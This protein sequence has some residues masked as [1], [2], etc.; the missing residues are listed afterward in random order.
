[1]PRTPLCLLLAAATVLVPIHVP[2]TAVAQPRPSAIPSA[3][4]DGLDTHLFRPALDSRGLVSVN[5]VGVLGGCDVRDDQRLVLGRRALDDWR[6]TTG[7]GVDFFPGGVERIVVL[8]RLSAA[9]PAFLLACGGGAAATSSAP[10][11]AAAVGVS[12]APEP[13]SKS[14][15]D[16]FSCEGAHDCEVKGTLA[17]RS[18]NAA[19]AG[20]RMLEKA[21]KLGSELGCVNLAKAFFNGW[22]GGVERPR[23]LAL[24]GS[25]CEGG[26][27]RACRLHAEILEGDDAARARQLFER[28]CTL[29]DVSACAQ[30]ALMLAKGEGGPADER[31]AGEVADQAC[32]ADDAVGCI[33]FGLLARDGMGMPASAEAARTAFHRG[34]TLGNKD[35]CKA[36]ADLR[37][38]ASK[39]N[40]LPA[41]D[42]PGANITVESIKADGTELKNIACKTDGLAGMLG[43]I[44]LGAG[45]KSRKGQLDACSPKGIVDTRVAWKTA[46]SR[47]SEV[48][49]TGKDAATSRCVERALAGAPSTVPGVCA[50]TVVHGKR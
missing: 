12:P 43:G 40:A 37:R 23:A 34:C 48:H 32:K 11:K 20:R 13:A 14:E 25:S 30:L 26:S 19:P 31:R 8:R 18:S 46:G 47:M 5:G 29:K 21:C 9:L 15:G 3:N 49:A 28:G 2:L 7:R 16:I 6:R 33:T 36:E 27:G 17:V 38:E 41:S 42:V 24:L 10:P 50:A 1:M 4:G 22:G 39:A 35:G 45:F 44:A